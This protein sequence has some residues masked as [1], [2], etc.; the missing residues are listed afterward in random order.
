MHSINARGAE[1]LKRVVTFP[2]LLLYGL[3][4]TVGAGIYILTGAVAGRAGIL[5]PVAFVI[6]SLL[7]LFTALSFAE[8]SARFPRAGGALVYVQE[9]LGLRWLSV[10][11]GLGTA[12]AG[13]ISAAAVSRGFVAYLSELTAFS[14]DLALAIVVI[15]VGAIAAW[16]V[17]LSTVVVGV[18]TLVEVGGLLA[19]LTFGVTHVATGPA[20]DMTS[21]FDGT[22]S[23]T[24]VIALL[25]SAV[26]CFYAFLGFEDMVNIAEE[27][28]DVRR[29]MPRAI[30]WTLAI[31]AALYVAVMS[32]AVLVVPAD[33]LGNADAPLALVFER[34]GGPSPMISSIALVAMLNGALVQIVMASRILFSLSRDG[35]LPA[36]VGRIHPRT[37]TPLVATFLITFGVGVFSATLPIE[38]LAGMTASVALGVFILVN[39]SLLVLLLREGRREPRTKGRLSPVIPAMGAIASAGFLG[40]EIIQRWNVAH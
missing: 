32:V 2:W 10:I 11:V 16:G 23:Q 15:G 30:V 19:V 22:S 21:T 1:P 29:V 40:L 8:L 13:M 25:H 18:I 38:R 26:L 17:K 35:I 4:S 24:A 27:V 6:A 20:L 28:R 12:A 34:S 5:A 33:E 9:G 3:G 31:S 36:W 7:A 37:S 39:T 14:S